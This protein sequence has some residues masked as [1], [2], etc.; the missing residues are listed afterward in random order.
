MSL[1]CP[2]LLVSCL[3]SSAPGQETIS[4]SSWYVP[5]VFSFG[6]GSL[7]LFHSSAVR[8]SAFQANIS[9]YELRLKVKFLPPVSVSLPPEDS[10]S[11][12][13]KDRLPPFFL[14]DFLIDKKTEEF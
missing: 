8:L 1:L 4:W 5:L 3:L 2:D 11:E 12:Y 14:S 9:A 6:F 13:P 10:L 7:L